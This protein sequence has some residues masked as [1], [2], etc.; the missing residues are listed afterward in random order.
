MLVVS[1]H[2]T[3]DD[4]PAIIELYGHMFDVHLLGFETGT[5][6]VENNGVPGIEKINSS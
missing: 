5:M 2:L 3:F 6:A 1:M 4:I